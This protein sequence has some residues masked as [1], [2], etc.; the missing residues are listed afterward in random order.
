M[1]AAGRGEAEASGQD[2]LPAGS[3]PT[4]GR[5]VRSGRAPRMPAMSVDRA[6]FAILLC[7]LAVPVAQAR[8]VYRCVRDGTVSLSTAPEPGSKCTARHVDDDAAKVPNLW[9]ELGTIRGTLY[10]RQ[11]DGKTVYGTRKLPGS[12]PVLRFTVATPPGSPA[13][14]GL[15]QVGKPR[16]D[17]YPQEFRS[18]AK[19]NKLDEAYLR[20]IAHAESG[21][22]PQ[23]TSPKGAQGVMQ[24]MPEVARE[25]GVSDPYASAQS[26]RAGAQLLARLLA[27]YHGDYARAAAAY[28]A[29][30]G[31]VAKYGGVPPYPETRVYVDKVTALHARYRAA[32]GLAPL[33][34]RAAE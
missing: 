13:H 33:A 10:E 22:D 25:H 19:A 26:I 31:A 18:A 32:M 3:W 8:T 30:A 4:S 20:A 34:L 6:L 5:A 17:M 21:Y 15:G 24:L 16:L 29:G 11:Q 14:A 7:I 2:R 9:G 23:A 27:K 28:N 1:T 12:V